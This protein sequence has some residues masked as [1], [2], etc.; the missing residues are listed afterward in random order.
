[1]TSK[2]T[3]KEISNGYVSKGT[4]SHE[5]LPPAWYFQKIFLKKFP[6]G[7][8]YIYVVQH[9]AHSKAGFKLNCRHML[10]SQRIS[11]RM[12]FHHSL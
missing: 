6:R 12:N 11:P 4:V 1:M 2:N 10:K 5:I 9:C 3:C 7:G 8:K